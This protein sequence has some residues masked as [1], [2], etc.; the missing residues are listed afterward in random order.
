MYGSLRAVTPVKLLDRERVEVHRTNEGSHDVV[1]VEPRAQT[2]VW[3]A[4]LP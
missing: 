1:V 2:D 4:P 3:I